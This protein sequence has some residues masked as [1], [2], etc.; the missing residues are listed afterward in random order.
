M[1]ELTRRY[2]AHS[3]IRVNNTDPHPLDS[4]LVTDLDQQTKYWNSTGA[5]KTFTHALDPTC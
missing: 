2:A 1:D 3:L 4:G 5:R